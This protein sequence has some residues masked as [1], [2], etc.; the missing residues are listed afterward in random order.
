[1]A[2]KTNKKIWL[3]Y[4]SGLFVLLAVFLLVTMGRMMAFQAPPLA[5]PLPP[6]PEVFSASDLMVTAQHISKAVQFQTISVQAGT[7]EDHTADF[8]AFHQWLEATYPAL[9]A[10]LKVEHV[11]RFGLIMTWQGRN[12]SLK[13]LIIIAHQDVVPA[14]DENHNWQAPPFSGLIKRGYIW[15]RGSIDDKGPLISIFEAVNKAIQTKAKP[16]RT[17]IIVSGFDEELSGTMG[18]KAMAEHLKQAGIKPYAIFDEGYPLLEDFPITNKPTAL[19]GTSEKGYMTLKITATSREGHSSTPPK[20]TAV[21]QLA[22]ALVALQNTPIRMGTDG[23]VH[24]MLRYV[25]S[26]L[27]GPEKYLIANGDIFKPVVMWA[28][29]RSNAATALLKT[30]MAPTMLK[31]SDKENILPQQAYALVNLRLHPRDNSADLTRQVQASLRSIKGVEV[32]VEPDAMQAVP[33]A[34]LGAPFELARAVISSLAPEAKTAPALMIAATDSHHL[35]GL[36][37]QIYRFTPMRATEEEY[38]HIHGFN[39]RLSLSNVRFMSLFYYRLIMQ[40][41]SYE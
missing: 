29:S 12:P 1:M 37:T 38:S 27:S 35:S 2:L 6:Q 19:I 17:L 7:N 22:L 15:G 10:T 14:P 41:G 21:G 9:Y 23:D 33:S 24:T 34:G 39:E 40:S 4:G 3:K 11:N 26:D 32:T 28:F 18:A 25:S 5:K 20:Q 31:G 36:S 16:E 30:T 8:I 13:P